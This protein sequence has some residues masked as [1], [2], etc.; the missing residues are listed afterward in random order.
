[1]AR[2]ATRRQG[3]AGFAL[4]E[5]LVVMVLV[6]I[7]AAIALPRFIG[8]ADKARDSEAKS[9]ARNMVSLVASCFAETEN[10]R[11]CTTSGRTELDAGGLAVGSGRGEVQVQSSSP[12]QYKITARSRSGTDFEITKPAGAP[13]E[14]TCGPPPRRGQNGCPSDG[15]W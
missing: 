12:E 4:I 1:M 6:G 10:F 14:R 3:Q 13:P 9:N 8:Q 2:S 5:L 7:L 11:E 15:N